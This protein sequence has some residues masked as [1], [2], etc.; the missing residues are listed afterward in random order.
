MT[1]KRTAVGRIGLAFAAFVLYGSLMPWR[2]RWRS[3]DAAYAS[4]LGLAEHAQLRFSF[5]D[6][7]TNLAIFAVLA[8]LWSA[9]LSTRPGSRW[10][11]VAFVLAGSSL[12]SAGIEFAQLYVPQRT[13]SIHDWVANSLGAAIGAGAWAV[14]GRRLAAFIAQASP[15]NAPR[16]L[17]SDAAQRAVVVA[18]LP[19]FIVLGAAGH[20]YSAP[21]L[22]LHEAT[23]RAAEVSLL[24][25]FYHQE[26]S[27]LIA[28]ASM[29]W[30]V[31]LYAPLGA[32][33][34]VLTTSA[35]VDTSMRPAVAAAVGA[36]V[37]VVLE[38]GRLFVAGQHPDLGNVVVAA[39]AAAGGFMLWPTLRALYGRAV[40]PRRRGVEPAA[41]APRNVPSPAGRVLALGL[42]ALVI[43]ALLKF[44]VL[45]GALVA[46][47]LLYTVVL[48]RWPWAWRWV[49]P[50]ALP[51]LDLAPLSGWFFLD[52]FDLLVL[53]TLAVSLWQSANGPRE[54]PAV[55]LGAWLWA[56]LAGSVALGTLLGTL[57]LQALDANAFASYHSHYNALRIGKGFLW[58]FVLIRLLRPAVG[59]PFDAGKHLTGGILAGLAGATALA[60]WERQA[61]P[62]LLDFSNVHRVGAFFSSMHNG[63]SH[64]EA[65]FVMA[66]PFLLAAA[67]VTKNTLLRLLG[68]ALFVAATYVLMVT[69]ARGGYAALGLSM[70]VA[71]GLFGRI[72]HLDRRRRFLGGVAVGMAVAGAL[73][74]AVVSGGFAQQRLAS[75]AGDLDVRTAHWRE[76]LRIMDPGLVTQLFGMGLGRFPETYYYR[77]QEH[78]APATFRYERDPGGAHLKLGSG[79]VVYVEQFVDVRPQR[80]YRLALDLR[81]A[82]GP[83]HVNVLL[84]ARTYFISY[85]WE[86]ATFTTAATTATSASAGWSH[87]E[88]TIRSNELGAGGWLSRRPVKLGL[89]NAAPGTTVDVRK[90]SLNDAD[91]QNLV[92]NG[93]F[94]NGSDHWFFSSNFNHLPWHIKNLWV[95]LYFDLGWFGVAAFALL[96][97][98]ALRDL[99]GTA[100]RG[101]PYAAAAFASAV[102]FLCVGLF[103]SLFDAPRLTT[104]FLLVLA[105]FGSAGRAGRAVD[106]VAAVIGSSGRAAA[107]APQPAMVMPLESSGALPLAAGVTVVAL[108]AASVPH[109]PGVPYNVRALLNPYH[110]F[111]AP[112]VLAVFVFWAAGVPMLTAR[113]LATGRRAGLL[114]PAAVGLHAVVAWALLREAVLPA[115]IHKVVGSPVL[116]WPWD[117]ETLLRFSAVQ[118]ALFLLLTGGCVIERVVMQ[119]SNRRALLIWLCWAACLLPPLHYAIVVQAATD[120]LTELMAGGGSVG[121][122]LMLALWC[123]LVGATGALFADGRPGRRV[124][125]GLRVCVAASSIALGYVILWLGLESDVQKYGASFSALQFLLS[126]DRQSYASAWELG[127][128]YAL[129]HAG[130]IGLIALVQLPFSRFGATPLY[131]RAPIRAARRTRRAQ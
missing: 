86:S 40:A 62:G 33:L 123:V 22:G 76:A 17:G 111:V 21:W 52:E 11:H 26:A 82:Q 102:G 64:I 41:S 100:W 81:S 88:V 128:R 36:G 19:Y 73:A 31:L 87:H 131:G 9:S 124:T 92:R 85:G 1:I 99:A 97:L 104:L 6:F 91:G 4:Y 66:M 127:L 112:V 30:Q 125:A 42:G 45:Q 117:W 94:S 12:F 44:P 78:K 2:L 56:A 47:L 3:F 93:D 59:E 20:W 61:Y 51:V 70:L 60:V 83:A 110:P 114:F 48:L 105:A 5:N 119:K 89:E 79:E 106:R 16:P 84:C 57:P 37:A 75:S 28:L 118:A 58:A 115:M 18:A 27:T 39:L 29:L 24:P 35:T 13:S 96:L 72:A 108:L 126:A 130:A 49:L 120:N 68:A 38:G 46:A 23:A 113:W 107:A 71:V 54:R 77:N 10:R 69:F 90:V 53:T 50:A 80:S 67:Y 43:A 122:S 65:Y 15:A 8:L 121:S 101:S 98:H 14:A 74:G 103:D 34:R 116:G 32:G 7:A 55:G 129:F 63:G 25:F 95:G 109:L